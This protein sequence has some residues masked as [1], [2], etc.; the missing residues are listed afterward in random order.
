MTRLLA[1]LLCATLLSACGFKLRGEADLPYQSIY[2][3]LPESST[4]RAKLARA[5][6]SGS[7]TT[8]APNSK[9]AQATFGI[10]G[11]STIKDILSLSSAGHVREYQLVRTFSFRVYDAN[12]RDVIP[13]GRIEL[14]RDIT[15]DDTEVLSKQQ[16]EVLLVKDMDD[17]LVQQIM[18]RLAASKPE[19][20]PKAEEKKG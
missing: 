9:E 2:I 1:A 16:E 11:D 12:G 4:F 8:I 13:P 17:D 10:T 5:I 6:T 7:K 20:A 19:F 15:Y 3:A 14:K 18:R